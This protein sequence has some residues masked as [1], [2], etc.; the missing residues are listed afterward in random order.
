MLP[1]FEIHE[2]PANHPLKRFTFSVGGVPSLYW[3]ATRP[4]VERVVSRLKAGRSGEAF[5]GAGTAAGAAVGYASPSGADRKGRARLVR[6][7][8]ATTELVE[9]KSGKLKAKE[10]RPAFVVELDGKAYEGGTDE[11]GARA[12]AAVAAFQTR[13]KVGCVAEARAAFKDFYGKDCRVHHVG[14]KLV[15]K[16]QDGGLWWVGVNLAAPLTRKYSFKPL[17]GVQVQL[18]AEAGAV[19]LRAEA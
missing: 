19:P 10:K 1:T 6:A 7:G 8:E 17:L 3:C 14:T 5:G 11:A 12:L 16:D 18:G 15:A 13:G 4:A 9:T 2:F